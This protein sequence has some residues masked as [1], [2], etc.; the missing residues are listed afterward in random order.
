MN[1]DR[2]TEVILM[3]K[4]MN[5]VH[6]YKFRKWFFYLIAS[7]LAFNVL[8]IT[9]AFTPDDNAIKQAI[10]K[11]DTVI[12]EKIKVD[13]FIDVRIFKP[14]GLKVLPRPTAMNIPNGGNNPGCLRPG[15]KNIDKYAIGVIEGKYGKYLAF[16]TKEHG[17]AALKT[18]LNEKINSGKYTLASLINI[19]APEFENNTSKYIYDVCKAT[20]LAPHSGKKQMLNKLPELVNIIANI[21]GFTRE[22]KAWLNHVD[23]I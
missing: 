2:I 9:Y 13:T 15:N 16:L 23:D 5:I 22:N 19:Y 17:F 10:S 18:F 12:I 8:L 4:D 14:D 3:G 20:G 21:E 7:S 1:K 11:T 6:R